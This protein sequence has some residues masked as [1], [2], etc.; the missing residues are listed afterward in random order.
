MIAA[1]GDLGRGTEDDADTWHEYGSPAINTTKRIGLV[2]HHAHTNTRTHTH[3][4]A[5]TCARTHVNT[6]TYVRTN[7]HTHTH[8]HTHK[9]EVQSESV[10]AV[11]HIGDISYSV[12]L[13]QL[14]VC[15]RV[16]VRV[17]VCVRA[18]VRT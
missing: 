4:H 7:T 17:C 2:K 8:T 14:P 13:V 18:C 11:F 16:C 9:Q 12:G 6:H 5:R 1:F 3:T 10:G 15:A